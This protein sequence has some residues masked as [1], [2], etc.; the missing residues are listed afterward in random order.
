[1]ESSTARWS[2][3]L[4]ESDLRALLEARATALLREEE[5][6]RKEAATAF[7]VRPSQLHCYPIY[8]PNYMP[9]HLS[10]YLSTYKR[11]STLCICMCMIKCI[12][13]QALLRESPLQEGA[14]WKT[15]R[16]SLEADERY[17][18]VATDRERQKLYKKHQLA[19]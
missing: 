4:N 7:M 17:A 9:T 15:A 6:A 16:G 3:I 11:N 5:V 1:M 2:D 8:L 14:P 19:V 10:I 12:R 13:V 18:A